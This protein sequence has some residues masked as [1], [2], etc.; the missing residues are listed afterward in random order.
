MTVSEKTKQKT[1]PASYRAVLRSVALR[2]SSF[3]PVRS[4]ETQT[5]ITFLQHFLDSYFIRCTTKSVP[6][7]TLSCKI[8]PLNDGIVTKQV[9]FQVKSVCFFFNCFWSDI[10][11]ILHSHTPPAVVE[12][13]SQIGKKYMYIQYATSTMIRELKAVP[14]DYAGVPFFQRHHIFVT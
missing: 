3:L 14:P 11:N 2:G 1:I 6:S 5:N 10:Y 13:Q 9:N 8:P 7:A 12:T 4:E